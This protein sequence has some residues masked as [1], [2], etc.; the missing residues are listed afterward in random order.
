MK[1]TRFDVPQERGGGGDRQ[2]Y[3]EERRRDAGDSYARRPVAS[4]RFSS[5]NPRMGN[6]RGG[7]ERS[8]DEPAID[9]DLLV[10]PTFESWKR[11]N[12][13]SSQEEAIAQYCDVVKRW[14]SNRVP[15]FVERHWCEDWF[16]ERYDPER[17]MQRR[18]E[19]MAGV[20][21][22]SEEI[23]PQQVVSLTTDTNSVVSGIELQVN[24][25][26]SAYLPNIPSSAPR[27]VLE[28]VLMEKHG[29][30]QLFIGETNRSAKRKD[31]ARKGIVTFNDQQLTKN[32]VQLGYFS[33]YV[34]QDEDGVFV[35]STSEKDPKRREVKIPVLQ[36]KPPLNRLLPLDELDRQVKDETQAM[37]CAK[38][39][40]LLFQVNGGIDKFLL[41]K[42]ATVNVLDAVVQYLR[43]V[44]LYCYFSG[45]HFRD[46]GEMLQRST[47]PFL[48]VSGGG[49]GG[50]GED[51]KFFEQVDLCAERITSN[52]VG[53]ELV[54]EQERLELAVAR[55]QALSA[56]SVEEF[57]LANIIE[58]K[59][60]GNKT[61][62]QCA[63]HQKVFETEQFLRKHLMNFHSAD[64][65]L[66]SRKL[67]VPLF[68][69]LF[70]A[71]EDKPL[72]RLPRFVE[73][74][75]R[76]EFVPPS[77]HPR[78]GDQSTPHQYQ[79]PQAAALAEPVVRRY[80]DP[81]AVAAPAAAATGKVKLQYR[82][83]VSHNL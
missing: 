32:L 47:T 76:D 14:A 39:L 58:V 43:Y 46:M 26:L 56:E 35:E 63:T 75:L 69:D 25:G 11:A 2:A 28:K 31:L 83:R 78:G 22:R 44:H 64:V 51:G 73:E 33:V 16:L 80:R 62:Y 8:E 4:S 9:E 66:A 70:A 72:P 6:Q 71:D 54:Q 77:Q 67:L 24:D 7:G 49:G 81:D 60:D 38:A 19:R 3:T 52:V 21:K 40:D 5:F 13:P 34:N 23:N 65:R 59:K 18:R 29:A 55:K 50:G 57:M 15:K 42:P 37:N 10:C 48:R 45:V 27:Q 61:H 79:S 53:V 41:N 68:Q 12:N 20:I 17:A 1:R 82:T 30:M 36:S 74:A